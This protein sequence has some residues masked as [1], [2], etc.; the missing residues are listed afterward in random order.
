MEGLGSG[1]QGENSE[2]CVDSGRICKF[3]QIATQ[4]SHST[5]TTSDQKKK[6]TMILRIRPEAECDGW[7]QTQSVV[8]TPSIFYRFTLSSVAP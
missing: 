3:Q 6:K 2:T 1:N 4:R 8:Q 7:G 5:G